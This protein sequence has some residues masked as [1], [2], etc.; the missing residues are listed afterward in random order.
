MQ[1]QTMP[2]AAID[3]EAGIENAPVSSVQYAAVEY[4]AANKPG[5]KQATLRRNIFA[6]SAELA[7]ASA[8]LADRASEIVDF[9]SSL[10]DNCGREET[11]SRISSFIESLYPPSSSLRSRRSFHAGLGEMI[12][13]RISLN[14]FP[15]LVALASTGLLGL[16]AVLIIR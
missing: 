16:A 3:A 8:I 13:N 5:R 9:A 15:W 10:P 14:R 12:V 4:A 2:P 7:Q 11:A 6:L 1:I